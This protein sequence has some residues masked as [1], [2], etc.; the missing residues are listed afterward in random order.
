MCVIATAIAADRGFHVII[1]S[2]ACET[3][4]SGSAEAVQILFG[5][6]WGSVMT[7]AD[8]I[9]WLK[10]GHPPERTRRPAPADPP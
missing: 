3:L 5:R 10:T 7:T 4:D 1:V 9:E 6:I 2:D 8:I